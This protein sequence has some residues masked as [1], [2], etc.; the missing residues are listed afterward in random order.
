[1]DVSHAS[2]LNGQA[3]HGQR[4]YRGPRHMNYSFNKGRL[5]EFSVGDCARWVDSGLAGR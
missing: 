2:D 5:E 1:M 3:A 4:N